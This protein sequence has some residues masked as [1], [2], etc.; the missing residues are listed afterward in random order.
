MRKPIRRVLPLLLVAF[1]GIAVWYF[2]RQ[3]EPP[4]EETAPLVEANTEFA[5][6]LFGQVRGGQSNIIFSPYSISCALGTL[7]AGARGQTAQAIATTAAF[8]QPTTN[9][10]GLFHDLDRQLNRARRTGGVDLSI[11]NAVWTQAGGEY[12]RDFLNLVQ[13]N[14]RAS[15][16]PVDFKNRP[17]E[18]RAAINQWVAENTRHKIPALFGPEAINHS[19]VLAIANAIYFKGTWAAVFQESDTQPGHFFVNSNRTVTV[20][21]MTQRGEFRRFSNTNL[22]CIVLPYRK[23]QFEM[24]ILLPSAGGRANRTGESPAAHGTCTID[25]LERELT[26]DELT[27]WLRAAQKT[28]IMAT[29]PKFRITSGYWL[30][31]VL[32]AMGMKNAFD[33]DR[34][35]FSGISAGSALFLSAVVH[36]ATIDVN[37]KGT[38]AA[39]ATGAAGT[40]SAAAPEEPFVADHPFLFLVRESATGTI[41]FMGRVMEPGNGEGSGE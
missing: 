23:G 3:P 34:A 39:A 12:Q 13:G 16:S 25:E 32:A 11:A 27:Q 10:A 31:D 30:N 40:N 9:L 7:H 20:P 28:E 8:P 21:M 1:A 38:E 19:T 15:A 29:I 14:Y 22:Q 33:Q 5:L 2:L 37:E 17:D 24:V 6:K 4:L 36:Q 41:L 26:D 35:D 18:A